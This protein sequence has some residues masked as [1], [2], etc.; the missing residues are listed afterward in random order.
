[1][2]KFHKKSKAPL[3]IGGL[4]VLCVA[5]LAAILIFTNG[6]K[7]DSVALREENATLLEVGGICHFIGDEKQSIPYRWSY[8]IS[9]E[10]LMGVFADEYEDH[11]GFNTKPGGDKGLR[12]LYFQALAPGECVITL[13][14]EDIRDAELYSNERV[15]TVVVE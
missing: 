14:Y 4:A 15:Y 8:T 6:N 11:S 3:I 10:S 5:V 9:D 1:M 13:R 7:I 2:A 12:K